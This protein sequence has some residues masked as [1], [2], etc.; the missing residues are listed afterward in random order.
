M[1]A[2]LAQQWGLF[3]EWVG[4]ER[5]HV[6]PDAPEAAAPR[7]WVHP[8]H[9]TVGSAMRLVGERLSE[10]G[11]RRARGV[12]V[13]PHDERAAWWPLTRHFQVVRRLPAGG[14]HLE[15][16]NLGQ[17]QPTVA[18]RDTLVLAFPRA[19]V[20]AA[21]VEEQQRLLAQALVADEAVGSSASELQRARQ[22]AEEAAAERHSPGRGGGHGR[23]RGQA[24]LRPPRAMLSAEETQVCHYRGV[25]CAGCGHFFRRGERVRAAGGAQVHTARAC[26]ER[27][28]RRREQA[29]GTGGHEPPGNEMETARA[30]ATWA[31]LEREYAL[32]PGLERGGVLLPRHSERVF[33]QFIRWLQDDE[34]RRPHIGE[35]VRAVRSYRPATRLVDWSSSQR[36]AQLLQVESG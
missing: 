30:Y 14:R 24:H 6:Q 1:Y 7:L 21:G 9:T 13:V 35:V 23:G 19:Q 25:S 22:S 28:M 29:E 34:G 11:A 18:R 27:A 10:P 3:S 16:N 32:G 12:I 20:V 33:G 26:A 2:S 5:R 8:T 31:R 15:A 36:I 17:W 4:A